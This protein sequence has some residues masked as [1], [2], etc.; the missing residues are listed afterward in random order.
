[1]HHFQYQLGH[2]HAEEVPLSR[3]AQQVGTPFYCYSSATLEHHYRVLESALTGLNAQIHYA[4]KANSNVAVVR[5]LANL[6]AGAD[7]VSEGELRLAMAAGVP[8]NRIVF[9]GVGK[10]RAE[11]TLALQVGIFQINV[12]SEPELNALS[13]V[14]TSLG[15]IAPVSLRVNPDIDAGTHEKI[16]TG[17]KE[18]KFGIEWTQARA[19]Y[20]K[21]RALPGIDVVGVAVHIGSQLTDLAP[22]RAAFL[23]VRDLVM[24]LRADGF[25]I[26][27][28]DVGGG[29]GVPYEHEKEHPPSPDA[30]AEMLRDTLES[31]KTTLILEPGRLITAN[32]GILVTQIVYVK[33]ST[34]RTFAIVDAAMNDLVRPAMYDA[35]HEIIPV[36]E[37]LPNAPRC[38]VDVVGPVCESGDTFAQQRSL[39][40]LSAGDL[41]VIGTAGAYGA[42]MASSYNARLLVPEVMVKGDAFAI[43]RHRPSYKEMLALEA[44]PEWL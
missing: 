19:V 21:A 40:L 15:L 37:P 31:L 6:G 43:V 8:A 36:V 10:T 38:I 2:L 14:A 18:N 26:R 29:L 28:I 39:P 44:L 41:L 33:E 9:S 35:Y 17:R 5:T 27:R 11:L 25:N 34:T 7:V 12:E 16:T 20:H 13:E 24:T 30:Y 3:I 32:A 4:M 1:M 22:F 23:R 42:V